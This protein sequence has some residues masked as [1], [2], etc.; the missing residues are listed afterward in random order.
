MTD[1]A[2]ASFH[3]PKNSFTCAPVRVHPDFQRPYFIQCDAS[4]VEGGVVSMES[5]E[6][7]SWNKA[8]RRKVA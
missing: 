4:D 5:F 8:S 7:R 2:F 3:A 1:E 6:V